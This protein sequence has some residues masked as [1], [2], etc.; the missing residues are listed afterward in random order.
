MRILDVQSAPQQESVQ[1]PGCASRSTGVAG[2]HASITIFRAHLHISRPS[3][4]YN[5]MAFTNKRGQ[6]ARTVASSFLTIK[7]NI[8]IYYTVYHYGVYAHLHYS[9]ADEKIGD[10][11]NIIM[12]I[13]RH[14]IVRV[15]F[16]DG[17]LSFGTRHV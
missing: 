8:I 14:C 4:Y 2:R 1:G 10:Y 13:Y 9:R 5:I 17:V 12:S 6:V 16:F 3:R 15:S 7:Q 11:N